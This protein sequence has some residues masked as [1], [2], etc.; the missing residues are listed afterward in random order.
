MGNV[1][2]LGDGEEPVVLENDGNV[3]VYIVSLRCRARTLFSPR[4]GN[5][6]D[7]CGIAL[8]P[9]NAPKGKQAA[10]HHLGRQIQRAIPRL[11]VQKHLELDEASKIL[12]PR[13]K[14]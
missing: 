12:F 1:R 10:V 7:A 6:R 2:G 14:T 8:D 13:C 5:E 11:G 3:D 4:K 9:S